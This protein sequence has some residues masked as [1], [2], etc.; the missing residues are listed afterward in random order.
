M[1]L[2]DMATRSDLP[3]MTSTGTETDPLQ[4]KVIHLGDK[5]QSAG[6]PVIYRLSR[7]S[8]L[9]VFP[10]SRSRSGVGRTPIDSSLEAGN[11]TLFSRLV[12]RFVVPGIFSTGR[13]ADG[14]TFARQSGGVS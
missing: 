14:V 9:G 13:L 12:P 11:N 6:V 5:V 7:A 1:P 10:L 8:F 2:I 3:P 4:M